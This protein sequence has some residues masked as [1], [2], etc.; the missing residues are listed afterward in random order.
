[1]AIAITVIITGTMIAIPATDIPLNPAVHHGSRLI[2]DSV[3]FS[4]TP[5]SLRTGLLQFSL[6]VWRTIGFIHH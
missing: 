1:L 5:T 6:T 4:F 3:G 2:T